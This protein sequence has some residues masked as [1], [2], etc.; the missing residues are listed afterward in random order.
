MTG[1]TWRYVALCYT[2]G[3]G[4]NIWMAAGM[5]LSAVDDATATTEASAL[6]GTEVR[7][8]YGPQHVCGVQV[9][10]TKSPT[11]T[12]MPAPATMLL[13]D[14]CGALPATRLHRPHLT[15][16]GRKYLIALQRGAAPDGATTTSRALRRMGLVTPDLGMVTPLALRLFG[17]Q[18]RAPSCPTT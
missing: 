17:E 16:A 7:T 2:R 13:V 10:R 9:A 6:I 12:P 8:A 4:Q 15:D 3:R 5:E 14:E 11:G 1:T 18:V